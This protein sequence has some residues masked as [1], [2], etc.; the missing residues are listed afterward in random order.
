MK[1]EDLTRIEPKD[2]KEKTPKNTGIYFW[3]KKETNEL[4]YI[5][6]GSGVNGLYNRIV[7]QHLNPKYIEYRSEKHSQEKDVF[8][9]Q[10]PIMKEVKGIL[11]AG[12]D[13]SA[14]RKNIGRNYQI[15]PGEATVN[16][17]MENL[18]F[19][20]FEMSDINELKE[21]EKE[22][23]KKHQPKLNI[24]HKYKLSNRI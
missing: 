22:L 16:F 20:Y 17:I 24:S 23:I 5:G 18:Y 12:I 21:L 14:F 4:I 15:K 11:K 3:F 6:T 9:L 1:I 13:Q 19:K 8:Q 2:A 7:R 10:H